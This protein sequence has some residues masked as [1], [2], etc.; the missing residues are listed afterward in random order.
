MLLP[1][2]S[3]IILVLSAAYLME[4]AKTLAGQC[5]HDGT[6]LHPDT[7]FTATIPWVER[8]EDGLFDF[9]SEP[10][11]H[12]RFTKDDSL[13]I[14]KKPVEL[15]VDTGS[16]GI[17]L[18]KSVLDD[19]EEDEATTTNEG[20]LFLSSS[21]RL[22]PGHWVWRNI[23]YDR[24]NVKSRVKILVISQ[25]IYCPNYIIGN[26]GR[27][28]KNAKDSKI[29][30]SP[31][32]TMMGIGFGRTEDGQAEGTPDKNPLL[33]IK[34]I[35][36]TPIEDEY[37]PGYIITSR[38][39]KIG[40]TRENF[41]RIGFADRQIHLPKPDISEYDETP[42]HL[43]PWSELRGCMS[44]DHTPSPCLE[45]SVLL[46]TGVNQSYIRVKGDP[47]NASTWPPWISKWPSHVEN[48]TRYLDAGLSV[49]VEF[50]TPGIASVSYVTGDSSNPV[51]PKYVNQYFRKNVSLPYLNT[52]RNV[53]RAWEV[54]FDP[55][56]GTV[57]FHPAEKGDSGHME[58]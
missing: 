8:P 44:I 13:D 46:D 51:T 47:A 50:G 25:S 53:F 42:P 10:T 2:I 56:R 31:N 15:M 21:K 5:S 26:D 34:E 43:Y 3:S 37:W 1:C 27:E 38:G 54:A 33:N 20:Y 30:S 24:R 7:T 40:L 23:F 14:T 32:T 6:V 28:C 36:S 58:L 45:S 55:V 41:E 49:H 29:N 4:A 9:V 17:V 57:S 48:R 19:W 16:C 18:A 22:Y 12:A 52:G 11:V 39:L 35:Q